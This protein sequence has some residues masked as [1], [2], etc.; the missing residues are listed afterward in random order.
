MSHP[1]ASDR[2]WTNATKPTGATLFLRTFLPYQAWRFLWINL[3]MLGI[4]ARS[5]RGHS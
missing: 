4:I 1:T 3:K 5:H 2:N